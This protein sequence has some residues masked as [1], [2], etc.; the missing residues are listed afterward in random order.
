VAGGFTSRRADIGGSVIVIRRGPATR[1]PN[2]IVVSVT[3]LRPS[4]R[5]VLSLV[6]SAAGPRS[7]A[8]SPTRTRTSPASPRI[9]TL[10]PPSESA[11]TAGSADSGDT[12]T[13]GARRRDATSICEATAAGT[14][15]AN[16]SCV[17]VDSTGNRPSNTTLCRTSPPSAGV[18]S[19]HARY[20]P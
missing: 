5:T 12:A 4:I 11:V 2:R 1:L 15:N 17:L 13:A 16:A 3:A 8:S 18:A 9:E 7:A 10:L 20:P 6:A 19:N 14:R